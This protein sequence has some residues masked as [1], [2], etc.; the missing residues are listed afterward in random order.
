MSGVKA[1]NWKHRRV[2]FAKNVRKETIPMKKFCCCLCLFSLVLLLSPLSHAQSDGDGPT[3]TDPCKAFEPSQL[4]KGNDSSASKGSTTA[5]S[6]PKPKSLQDQLSDAL[7]DQW[8]DAKTVGHVLKALKLLTGSSPIPFEVNTAVLCELEGN[9]WDKDAQTGTFKCNGTSKTNHALYR[10][11]LGLPDEYGEPTV[12]GL[13]DFLD[14]LAKANHLLDRKPKPKEVVLFDCTE[15][16]INN[17]FSGHQDKMVRINDS[18]S[19]KA[20]YRALY[21]LLRAEPKS[22]ETN[23]DVYTSHLQ[24]FR[25]AFADDTDHLA[26]QV[27]ATIAPPAKK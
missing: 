24:D 16:L 17:I 8:S 1:A 15:S 7:A 25:A 9:T 21:Q 5:K 23:A 12:Q 22:D 11:A 6:A 19:R 13:P 20:N 14:T 2:R 10:A 4:A 18:F 27:A 26:K 3:N